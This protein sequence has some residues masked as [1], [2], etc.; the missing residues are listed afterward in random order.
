MSK[1]FLDT[2]IL[3]YCADNHS[4]VKQKKARELVRKL[5]DTNTVVIST[6]VLQEFYVTVTKKFNV[7]P[8]MA[9]DIMHAFENFEI[10]EINPN[11]IKDAIDCSILNRIS[12][13]DALIIVT[14]EVAKCTKIYSEDLNHGQK[15]R[16]TIIQNPFLNQ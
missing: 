10:I 15:I 9:K 3:I 6:Q 7:E 14:A 12:F 11:I 16:G 13:W 5:A 4:P 8:L 1:A 2:N